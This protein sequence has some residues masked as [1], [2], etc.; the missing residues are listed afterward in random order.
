MH[1]SQELLTDFQLGETMML[2]GIYEG[3]GPGEKLAAHPSQSG[4]P[5]PTVRLATSIRHWTQLSDWYTTL[6]HV[7]L[8]SS[9]NELVVLLNRTSL[10]DLRH[11]SRLMATHNARTATQLRTDWTQI[12]TKVASNSPNHPR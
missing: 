9:F 7:I 4:T 12:L 6:P 3:H 2:S 11:V 10:H 8:Y 5:D 1:C